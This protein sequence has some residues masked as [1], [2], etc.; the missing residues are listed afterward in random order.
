[1]LETTGAGPLVVAP[2]HVHMSDDKRRSAIAAPKCGGPAPCA[3][4]L[5]VSATQVRLSEGPAFR[6]A[7]RPWV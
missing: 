3:L 4:A 2:A 6:I 5:A 7:I 1:M